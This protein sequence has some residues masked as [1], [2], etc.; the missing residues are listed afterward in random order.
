MIVYFILSLLCVFGLTKIKKFF[1]DFRK[2]NLSKNAT[3]KHHSKKDRNKE[4]TNNDQ[5]YNTSTNDE[6]IDIE[7]SNSTPTYDELIDNNKKLEEE[8]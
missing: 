1:Q 7:S 5:F 4:L 3:A 6:K 2:K 8:T